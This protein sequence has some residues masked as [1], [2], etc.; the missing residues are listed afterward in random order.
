MKDES[1]AADDLAA[2]KERSWREAAVIDAAFTSGDLDQEGWHE[3]VRAL[4]EPA[5]L[6]ADNPRAQSGH[7]G[8]A[9]HWERARRLLVRALPASGGDF[10]DV[11]CANGHLME[12]LTAWA[13]QD[14]IHIEPYGVEISEALAALARERCP[15]WSGRI[16]HANAMGWEP[17]RTFAIVRTGL[18]YVP[19]QLR[20]AYV[21]HL[22]TR[23]VAPGGRLIIGVFNE[24]RDQHLLERE[25]TEM[26][27]RV[28]GRVTAPHRHPALLYKAFSVESPSAPGSAPAASTEGC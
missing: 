8:D 5:Y 3:A 2:S 18:D 4:I 15:Q 12:T 26:G 24:E 21:E 6:A 16:W 9:A 19:P 23:V 27:H 20:G 25:I 7:S 17:S 13:T 28:G 22:L 1:P 11:G 10:L 14:G